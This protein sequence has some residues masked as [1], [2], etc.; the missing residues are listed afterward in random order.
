M[1]ALEG[2]MQK[3]LI[4]F[5]PFLIMASLLTTGCTQTG[6]TAAQLTAQNGTSDSAKS[7]A[8]EAIPVY[9][10]SVKDVSNKAKI[11]S[12]EVGK[13][14]EAKTILVKFDD[15]TKGI[16]HAV[17]G[18]ASIINYE[19]RDGEPWATV[20]KPK[21]AQLPA[22]V[23]EVKTA[24]LKAM[25][26]KGEKFTLIDSRPAGRN[27]QGSLPGAISIPDD[28]FN[29]QTSKL[30]ADRDELL[31]FFCGGVTCGMSTHSAGLAKKMGYKN[32]KAYLEGEPAW[33]KA[34][35]PLYASNDFISKGNIILVDLRS[36]KKSEAGR[37]PRS[38]TIPSATLKEKAEDFPLKAPVVLYS[39]STDESIKAMKVLKE[40]GL[41]TVSLVPGNIDGWIKAGGETTSGPVVSTINWK[42]KMEKGEVSVADFM[43]VVSGKATDAVILDVRNQDEMAECM[44]KNAIAIPLDQ[45]G[46]RKGELPKDKKIYLHCTTGARAS[47][48]AKELNKDGYQAF[49]L[50][51][52]VTCENNTCT[53][54]E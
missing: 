10:G 14:A 32:V 23:T 53:I 13:G 50:G 46:K 43:N 47:M 5:I 2:S 42:R 40:E 26:D 3:T 34:G 49:F 24:E 38:V 45:V 4:K 17:A 11:I 25:L 54:A 29:N 48:A 8:P 39:D 20:I 7:I 22:G 12:I 31:V 37:I 35:Y 30:P 6:T 52:D 15:K 28:E 41:K 21:L 36:V 27:A 18:H 51:E 9:V 1:S 44:F 33:S 19:M 16:E